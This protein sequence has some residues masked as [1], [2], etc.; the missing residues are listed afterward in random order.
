M[1]IPGHTRSQKE[2]SIITIFKPARM[3]SVCIQGQFISLNV[4]YKVVNKDGRGSYSYKIDS[5]PD[6]TT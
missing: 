3:S 6:H 4:F 5:F 1:W 2:M